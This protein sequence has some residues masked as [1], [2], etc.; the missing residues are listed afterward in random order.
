MAAVAAIRHNK[1]IRNFYDS[2]KNKGKPSKVAIV[3]CM[4]KMLIYANSLVKNI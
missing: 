4:R 2:L 1:V 3:A